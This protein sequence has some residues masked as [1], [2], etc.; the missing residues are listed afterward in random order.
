MIAVA[1]IRATKISHRHQ[2]AVRVEAQARFGLWLSEL[3][4]GDAKL[5][6]VERENRNTAD[7]LI[8]A[9]G[10]ISSNLAAGYGCGSGPERARYYG[11]ALTSTRES[12]DWYF[13][14]RD[15][16]G[17]AVVEQRVVVLDRIIR[18]L[19]VIIPRERLRGMRRRRRP[20]NDPDGPPT[21]QP[22]GRTNSRNGG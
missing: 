9:V 5:L 2:D 1:H 3:A 15:T 16:L 21:A 13:K 11:Y 19:T 18:I 12:I 7:Q 22:L 17:V 20:T 10:A 4:K 8:R 14:A 6:H